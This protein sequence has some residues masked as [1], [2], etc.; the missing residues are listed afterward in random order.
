MKIVYYILR[1]IR[2]CAREIR[3]TGLI[4]V[5]RESNNRKSG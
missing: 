4:A 5:V 1:K 3:L 2:K